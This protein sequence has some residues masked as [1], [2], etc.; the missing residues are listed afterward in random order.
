MYRYRGGGTG[1]WCM[2]RRTTFFVKRITDPI[3]LSMPIEDARQVAVEKRKWNE[4]RVAMVM[5][6]RRSDG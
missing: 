5:M 2:P 1:A 6:E 4:S 3:E